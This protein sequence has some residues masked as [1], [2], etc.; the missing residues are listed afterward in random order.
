MSYEAFEMTGGRMSAEAAITILKQGNFGINS[1]AAMEFFKGVKY[2]SLH[3]DRAAR[4]IGIRP[5]ERKAPHAYEIRGQNGKGAVQ[6]SGSA[7]LRFFGIDHKATKAYPCKWNDKEKL[8]EIQLE[9]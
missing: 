5:E 2:A 4:R 1:R 6:I 7:F 9:K 3:Y 8:I